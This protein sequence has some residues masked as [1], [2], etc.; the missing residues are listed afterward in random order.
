[1]N[2]I[3]ET[4]NLNIKMV[5]L[6]AMEINE[7]TEIAFQTIMR[8]LKKGTIKFKEEIQGRSIVLL[9]DS[10]STH[11][12]I[13]QRIVDELKIPVIEETKFRVTIGD[14]SDIVGRGI[15][16]KKNKVKLPKLVIQEDY[17][18]MELGKIDV[19]LEMH[20]LCSTGFMGVH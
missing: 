18:A 13:Y 20:W 9:I 3:E 4:E 19:I 17:L 14:G 12:F 7:E 11:N 5:D 2:K 1:M 10:E 16:K 6:K 8:F 15:C